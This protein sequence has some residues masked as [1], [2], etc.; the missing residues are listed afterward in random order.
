MTPDKADHGQG[1]LTFSVPD[2]AIVQRNPSVGSIH[3]SDRGVQYGADDYI[4]ILKEHSFTISMSRKGNPYDNAQAESF[5]KT[6]KA[7]EYVSE[8]RRA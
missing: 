6:S 7:E 3:H 4:K 8:Y 2:A 5:T 1:R